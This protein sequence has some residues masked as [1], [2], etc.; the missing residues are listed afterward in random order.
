MCFLKY[1]NFELTSYVSGSVNVLGLYNIYTLHLRDGNFKRQA[2]RITRN[3]HAPSLADRDLPSATRT[4]CGGAK[5]HNVSRINELCCGARDLNKEVVKACAKVGEADRRY[6][7][8][9]DYPS[10]NVNNWS[11][12]VGSSVNEVNSRLLLRFR[13]FGFAL[14]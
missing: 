7:M 11:D 4:N 8:S 1:R 13:C 6:V 5:E 10:T 9:R 2:R 14:T 3:R 12:D